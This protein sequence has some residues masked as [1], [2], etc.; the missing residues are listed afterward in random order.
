LSRRG[1]VFTAFAWGVVNHGLFAVAISTMLAAL[2]SGLSTGGG[3]LVGG[4]AWISNALLTV[5]FPL[6]HS[7][8]LSS[9]GRPWLQ[10]LAPSGVSRDLS[11]TTFT[12]LSSLQVL[13]TF[14]LWSPSGI[15]LWEAEGAALWAMRAVFATSWLL[16][17]VALTHAGLH[18]QTG[19]IGWWSIV[20]GRKPSF[21]DF[22]THGWF[23]LCRQPVY[24]CFALTLWA[25]PVYTLD[26]IVLGLTWSAY[27]LAAPLHKERRYLSYYGERFARYRT[28][29]PYILPRLKP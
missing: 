26:R 10:R 9:A 20:R 28:E 19:S 13:A 21:G 23:R 15:V 17:V 5:Q 16:L 8:L 7:F 11:P 12:I 4:R 1:E 3:S 27:C 24:L 6:L 18:I 14:A 25:G 29:V 2:Y 22:P